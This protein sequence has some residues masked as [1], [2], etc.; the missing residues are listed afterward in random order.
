M[1]HRDSFVHILLTLSLCASLLLAGCATDP[2]TLKQVRMDVDW[3]MTRYRNAVAAGAVTL[4][5]QQQVSEAY[6]NYQKAFEDAV[7]AAHSNYETPAP[8]NV[9]AL[10]NQVIDIIAAIPY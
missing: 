1:K 4:G 9:K 7:Q 2:A 8:A 3:P 5:E 6:N 10:A